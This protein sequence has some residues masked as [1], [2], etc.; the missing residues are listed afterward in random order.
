MKKSGAKRAGYVWKFSNESD[1]VYWPA[2]SSGSYFGRTTKFVPDGSAERQSAGI[3][4]PESL[5][6]DALAK[7][8][9]HAGGFA[10]KTRG[11]YHTIGAHKYANFVAVISGSLRVRCN[12]RKIGVSAGSLFVLP[13]DSECVITVGRAPAKILWFHLA[14][15]WLS[16]CKGQNVL[17]TKECAT[18]PLL[19]ALAKAYEAEAFSKYQDISILANCADS[20]SN[21]LC[22]ELSTAGGGD[23]DEAAKLAEFMEDFGKNPEIISLERAA[24][25]AQVGAR[26]L[27][28]YCMKTRGVNFSKF[29]KNA[30]MAR[31]AQLAAEGFDCAQIAKKIGYASPFSFSRAFFKFFGKRPSELR[32]LK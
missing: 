11:Y 31:A 14:G 25:K 19:T 22:R 13:P 6:F 27:D 16:L 3:S 28:I 2:G 15:D 5:A 23:A 10:V 4:A 21:A 20:I 30:G 1:M 29:A 18:L 32:H 8:G 26:K 12:T 7:R 24:R 9:I 17:R